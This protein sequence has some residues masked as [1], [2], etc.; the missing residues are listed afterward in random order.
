MNN[1]CLEYIQEVQEVE[2][3]KPKQI[4]E[5]KMNYLSTRLSNDIVGDLSELDLSDIDEA[6]ESSTDL[7]SLCNNLNRML[8]TRKIRSLPITEDQKVQLEDTI[9][10]N[11]GNSSFD[12]DLAD[13]FLE[14][15]SE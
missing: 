2:P 1:N 13:Q 7:Y 12:E 10:L 5:N 8:L 9:Y 11:C 6:I 15:D 4:G 14:S 3:Q